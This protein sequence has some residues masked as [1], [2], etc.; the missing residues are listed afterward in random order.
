MVRVLLPLACALAASA[1]ACSGAGPVAVDAAAPPDSGVDLSLDAAVDLAADARADADAD[2]AGPPCA[3]NPGWTVGQ[4][5]CGPLAAA[6]Y[7]LLVPMRSDT[8]YLLDLHGRWVHSWKGSTFPA[9]S[10]YVLQDG[11]L[12]R[13]G[14]DPARVKFKDG[15]GAGGLV[16]RISWDGAVAWTYSYAGDL[17]LQHHDAVALPGGNVLLVAW[18]RKTKAQALAAGRDPKLLADGELWVDH[19]VEIKPVGASGGTIVWEWHLW[20]HLVQDHDAT[21]ANHG[22]VADHPELLDLNYTKHPRADW[23]HVNAVAYHAGLDQILISVHNTGEVMVIDHGTTTA[24]AAGHTGG[25]R[26]RGGDILYRWGNP[27]AHRAGQAADQVLFGQHDAQWIAPGLPGAGNLLL[28]NNGSGRPGGADY[29]SVDELTPPLTSGGVYTLASGQAFGPTA[30][31]W[32]YGGPTQTAFFSASISGAQRLENSNTLI[33]QGQAGRLVEVT[34]S[35]QIVWEY[36][37]PITKTGP[38][39]Q[40]TPSAA[41]T[42]NVFKARRY[43]PSFAGLTGRDLSPKGRLELPQ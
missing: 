27:A 31:V 42:N 24:E 21:K 6:G 41:L 10:A 40:G 19:L 3:D 26:G 20:D 36:I 14:R 25:A 1:L 18:E 23:T 22:K 39:K 16:Q 38:V 30:P 33:C 7:T 37:N 12:L 15:G 4:L 5:R 28:F 2:A 13:T 29:S 11:S 43:P 34:P 17:H 32:R 35:K 8:A 9:L